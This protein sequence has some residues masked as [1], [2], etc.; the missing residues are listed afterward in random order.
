MLGSLKADWK[1]KIKIDSIHTWRGSTGCN[2][3]I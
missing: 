1:I 3:G 2:C